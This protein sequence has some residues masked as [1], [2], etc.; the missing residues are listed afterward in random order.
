M[1]NFWDDSRGKRHWT[2]CFTINFD[3]WKLDIVDRIF[4]QGG[5]NDKVV[6]KDNKKSLFS[7]NFLRFWIW[8]GRLALQRILYGICACHSKS[9]LFALEASCE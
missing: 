5:H 7:Q 6:R 3:D 8:R 4:G 2:L 1:P 9:I